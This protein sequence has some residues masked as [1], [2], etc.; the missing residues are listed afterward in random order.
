MKEQEKKNRQVL[1]TNHPSHH[2]H[3]FIPV[4][5]VSAF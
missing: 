1:I 3:F 2:T 5:N 4:P